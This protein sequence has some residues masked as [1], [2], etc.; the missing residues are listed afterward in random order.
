MSTKVRTPLNSVIMGLTLLKEE[1]EKNKDL[2][3]PKIT[4]DNGNDDCERGLIS[5]VNDNGLTKSNGQ[6][7]GSASSEIIS[8]DASKIRGWLDLTS[9]IHSNSLSAVAVLNDLLNYDKI[10]MGTMQLEY[11][12]IDI[13]KLLKR[14][15]DEFVLSMSQKKIKYEVDFSAL[16]DHFSKYKDSNN[17]NGEA[18]VG[19]SIRLSQ[20]IRNLLSN[21]QK[22]TNQDGTY[23]F[24]VIWNTHPLFMTL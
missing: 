1:I 7:N 19:D 16:E 10:E 2:R 6:M 20:C 9:E 24:F 12:I 13:C 8:I 5:N 14:T 23:F 15:A 11:T 21:S 3:L 17:V 22:F 4:V 18:I